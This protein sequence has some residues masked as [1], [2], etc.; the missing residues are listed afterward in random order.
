MKEEVCYVKNLLK[1][2]S[3]MKKMKDMFPE[4]QIKRVIRNPEKYD[5]TYARTKRLQNQVFRKCN[6]C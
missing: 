1:S 4:K 6:G 5:V 2:A 3:K